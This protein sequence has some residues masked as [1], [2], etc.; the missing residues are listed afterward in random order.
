[1]SQAGICG[2]DMLEE[3][4]VKV[5]TWR[6]QEGSLSGNSKK[7]NV[8]GVEVEYARWWGQDSFGDGL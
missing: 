5:M 8:T 6:V 1:M 7:A 3:G 4:T 2:K